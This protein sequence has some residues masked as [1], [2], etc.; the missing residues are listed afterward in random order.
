LDFFTNY[1]LLCKAAGKSANGVAK[2]LGIASGSVTQWKQGSTPRPATVERIAKYFGVTSEE[3]LFGIK[4]EPS[5]PTS[6]ELDKNDAVSN[7]RDNVLYRFPN[8]TPQDV[9]ALMNAVEGTELTVQELIRIA[10][11]LRRM[12]PADRKF[13]KGVF[14]A[15]T[16]AQ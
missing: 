6:E 9:N 8:A 2:E 3:L 13:V 4:K 16:E 11:M 12:S 15:Y 10:E 7:L 5:T 1:N 14:E